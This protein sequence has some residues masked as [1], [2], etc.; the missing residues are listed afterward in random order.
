MSQNRSNDCP[1]ERVSVSELQRKNHVLWIGLIGFAAVAAVSAGFGIGASKQ[2]Q[3]S[4]NICEAQAADLFRAKVANDTLY[5]ENQKLH[6]YA[7][8]AHAFSLSIRPWL[9]ENDSGCEKPNCADCQK[10][11]AEN[12]KKIKAFDKACDT[13]NIDRA[14][15]NRL[16]KGFEMD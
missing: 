16:Q 6:A 12:A 14:R 11:E 13:A 8:E 2:A 10:M 5:A 1:N 7:E 9:D 4:K 15:L 3:R